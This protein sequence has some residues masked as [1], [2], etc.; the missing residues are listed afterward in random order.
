VEKVK[1]TDEA[2]VRPK[3]EYRRYRNYKSIACCS[4][5]K[6]CYSQYR[7]YSVLTVTSNIK[8]KPRMLKAVKLNTKKTTNRSLI[9]D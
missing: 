6:S 8:Y 1:E 4:M 3:I 2:G 7:C 5:S 9:H